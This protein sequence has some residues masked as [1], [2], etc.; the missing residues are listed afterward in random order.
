MLSAGQEVQPR[1]QLCVEWPEEGVTAPEYQGRDT[2]TRTG[3]RGRTE[4]TVSFW[5]QGFTTLSWP[6]V[7]CADEADL[8]LWVFLLSPPKC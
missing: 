3:C 6:Q 4:T 1:A 2:D 8:E 7:H 5:R